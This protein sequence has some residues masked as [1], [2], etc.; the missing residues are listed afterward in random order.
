MQSLSQWLEA[1]NLGQ[2][3]QTFANNE[4]GLEALRLL[5]DAD[6]RELGLPLGPRKVLLRAIAELNADERVVAAEQPA[7]TSAAPLAVGTTAPAQRRPPRAA[8]R[9]HYN[10]R[11]AHKRAPPPRCSS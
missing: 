11:S 9:Y 7:T 4:V 3:A 1:L 8:F 5:D 6:L 10:P 2:Y